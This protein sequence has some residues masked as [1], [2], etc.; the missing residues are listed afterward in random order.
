MSTKLSMDIWESE[1]VAENALKGLVALMEF[2]H[3]DAGYNAKNRRVTIDDFGLLKIHGTYF[4][5]KDRIV[6]D[7]CVDELNDIGQDY[8]SISYVVDE[9][10]KRMDLRQFY[11]VTMSA[12]KIDRLPKGVYGKTES[13]DHYRVTLWSFFRKNWNGS[14]AISETLYFSVSRLNGVVH[15]CFYR[16]HPVSYHL[17]PLWRKHVSDGFTLWADRK[18]LWNVTAMEC[19]LDSGVTRADPL[20]ARVTFG[21]YPEHVKSLLYAR[22][23]PM[24]EAGRRRPILHWVSAHK[25]RIERGVDVDITKHLRGVTALSMGGINF[26]ITNPIKVVKK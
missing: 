13:C 1:E 10:D 2:E 14:P 8:F 20:N 22:D 9:D 23:M 17:S 24:T 18:H 16:G 7:G 12:R 11:L 19:I 25:R 5:P 21:V 15:P 3:H 6:I 4:A 26:E